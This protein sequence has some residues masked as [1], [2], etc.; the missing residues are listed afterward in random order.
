MLTL[1]RVTLLPIDFNQGLCGVGGSANCGQFF[2]TGSTDQVVARQAAGALAQALVQPTNRQLVVLTTL[3]QPTQGG[4]FSGSGFLVDTISFLGGSGYTIPTLTTPA[5]TYTLIFPG[6]QPQQFPV[7]PLTPVSSGVVNSSSAFGQQGQT[8]IVRGVMARDNNSLYFPSVVSQEDGKMNGDGATTLSIDY[9]FYSISTQNPIDWPL[10]DTSGHIAA[11]H[12]ASAKFLTNHFQEAGPHR[13]DVR[14]FYAGHP[15][16]GQYNTDFQCPNSVANSPCAYPGDGQGFTELD[17]AM[18]NEQLYN[19]LSALNDTNNYLGDPGIGSVIEGSGTSGL[20]PEVIDA[21]YE[22][23]NGQLGATPSTSVKASSFDW[24]N[25]AAGFTSIAAAA[26]GPADLPIIAAAVGVTSGALWAGSALDPWWGATDPATPPNYENAFDTTLGTLQ[27]NA[28]NYTENLV[29]SYETS[30]DNIYTD[31]GKL[32]ATGAKTANSDSG[33]SFPDQVSKSAV[34]DQFVAG[35]RR[36][37]YLQLLP[38]FYWMDNYS[39]QPV[40]SLDNLGMFESTAVD[41][42]HFYHWNNSCNASYPSA[43]TSNGYAYRTY[44][45]FTNAATTDIFVIGGTINNQGTMKVKESLPSDSLLNTLF[46]TGDPS[47][48]GP[49]NIPQDLVYGT[50]GLSWRAGGPN[51]GTYGGVTQCYQPSCSDTT[52]LPSQSSCIAA[53]Q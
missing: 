26:L 48:T 28:S 36:S 51:A 27:N 39:A 1:D 6:I 53:A 16:M 35:V 7:Q 22:V 49:L 43:T 32:A 4:V 42:D 40:S 23:L 13:Q 37:M 9:N 5:S 44:P 18:A 8:G 12:W 52:N 2:P 10:T 20:A 11:Y 17:L 14:Y 31:W 24:M 34:V 25:L 21:S 15:E 50:F 45:S 46:G 30:L 3:G 38:K 33:W 47:A 41:E 29:S 19:E